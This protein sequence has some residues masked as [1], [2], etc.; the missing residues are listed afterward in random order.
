[1]HSV[2]AVQMRGISKRYS[3]TL[4]NDGVDLTLHRGEVH[5]VLGENGAGKTTLMSILF[6]LVAPDSGEVLLDGEP[7]GIGSPHDALAR[8]AGM[9]HQ[10]FMLVPELSVAENVVLGTQSA[11]NMRLRRSAIERDVREV[12]ERF[13]V[14]L[15][16]A[17]RTGT[18]PVEI[19]QRVEILKLLYRGAEILILD[20]PTA[21]LGP[22]QVEAL[23]DV[24]RALRD[25]GRAI[26]IVTHKLPEVMDVADRVTVLKGGRNVFEG[27][28][29]GFDA[30]ALARAM[31][32]AALPELPPR[33]ERADVGDSVR[34]RASGLV[35]PGRG[36]RAVAGVDLELMQSEIVGVAGVEGNGQRELYGVLTGELE[37][38]EGQ[39]EIDGRPVTGLSPRQLHAAGLAAVPADRQGA[40]LV[41]DMS[42]ADNLALAAVPAGRF[43]RGGLL[44]RRAIRAEA[45]RLIDAHNIVPGDPD[46]RAGSLSGGNQQKVV[47][48]R[49][50]SRD[51]A[52]LVAAS[53]TQ[54]LDVGAAA[55]VHRRLLDVR[56]AGS[57]ILLI[58]YDLDELLQLSDR[59]V[60]LHRGQIVY[61]TA[62]EQVDIDDLGMAMAGHQ[63]A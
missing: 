50:L 51:P 29:G 46:L 63:P 42:V 52:V 30:P 6:G 38:D 26:A 4:A 13:G 2:P 56:E 23:L 37:A 55:D 5:A 11:W 48:A 16:P 7:A 32:G 24:L 57:A 22:A 15:D 33:G 62:A 9:V 47:L 20:E 28:R 36:G 18:L 45:A 49:E 1:M 41:L 35:V 12:G 60:V 31:T 54:G 39:I 14:E 53:P 27:E 25:E 61:E 40:G 8:G 58:T 19:Q 10:H 21:V 59:I 43:S 44:R 17:A 34:L 3:E